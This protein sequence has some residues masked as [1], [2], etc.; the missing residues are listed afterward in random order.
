MD[1][2]IDVLKIVGRVLTHEGYAVS[3]HADPRDALAEC[4]ANPPDLIFTDLMLPR[5]DG[6][7]FIQRVR[8]AVAEPPPIIILS[9]SGIRVEVAERQKVAASLGKPFELNDI[10]DLATQMCG[11]RG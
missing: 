9:A 10:R 2:D 7:T 8:A 4:E 1:D 5:M 6:E 3:T 11:S